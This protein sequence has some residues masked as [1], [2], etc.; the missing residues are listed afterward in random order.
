MKQL[1]GKIYILLLVT[2]SI[3]ISMDVP[4]EVQARCCDGYWVGRPQFKECYF[5]GS[6]NPNTFPQFCRIIYE[7]ISCPGLYG[8]T[9]HI[10]EPSFMSFNSFYKLGTQ[11]IT[12]I[13]V[14]EDDCKKLME[15]KDRATKRKQEWNRNTKKQKKDEKK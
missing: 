11:Q 1:R 3:I 10:E 6:A 14:T 9:K 12:F 5:D 13:E 7:F 2:S 8:H 15:E 4:I